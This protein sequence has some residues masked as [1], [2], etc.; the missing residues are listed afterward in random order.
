MFNTT[1][2]AAVNYKQSLADMIAAVHCDWVDPF[3]DGYNLPIQDK[4]ATEVA[5]QLIHFNKDMSSKNMAELLGER[6]NTILVRISRA[7]EKLRNLLKE[8]NK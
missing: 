8:A 3:F 7:K 1:Y 2:T 6:E 4:D 5:I